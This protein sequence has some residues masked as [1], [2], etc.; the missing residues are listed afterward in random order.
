MGLPLLCVTVSLLT[1]GGQAEEN[2]SLRGEFFL[3]PQYESQSRQPLLFPLAH[4]EQ[5]Y[6]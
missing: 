1:L 3:L 6:G 5:V 4:L 2:I